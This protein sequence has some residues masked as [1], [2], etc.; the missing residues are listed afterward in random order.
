[1][2]I[3]KCV[4]FFIV[5]VGRSGT[6]LLQSILSSHSKICMPPETGFVRS[7]ILSWRRN[8]E[9][10]ANEIVSANGKLERIVEGITDGQQQLFT[11][12]LYFYYFLI[13]RYKEVQNKQKIG[14]KDPRL[15]EFM[16]AALELFPSAKF[17]HLVRDP[18]DV[19]LSKK[20]AEWSKDKPSW[21]HIFANYIQLKIGESQGQKLSKDKYLLLTYEK[22]LD[23]P[24]ISMEKVCNFLGVKFEENMLSFQEKAKELV[25]EDEKQWKKETMGPLLKNNTGKWKGK[26]TDTEVA[27]TEL[28]C[29][30]AFKIGGYKKSESYS[31][32]SFVNKLRVLSLSFLLTILGAIYIP[33]RLWSQKLLVAWKY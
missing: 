21:Y 30:Q 22:L 33:C 25:S 18:R 28:L 9:F 12:K 16:K 17:I 15:V 2:K 5:G 19:L 7:N 14:D 1:M 31:K 26:L 23:E 11:N 20:K 4:S 10:T 6:S 27:L 3:N 29:K 32:L 8:R 13:E 24:E